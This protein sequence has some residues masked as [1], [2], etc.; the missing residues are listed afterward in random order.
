MALDVWDRRSAAGYIWKWSLISE[1]SMLSFHWCL[2][3]QRPSDNHLQT[4]G[5]VTSLSHLH[6]GRLGPAGVLPGS[7]TAFQP[8][9]S[10]GPRLVA[11]KWTHQETSAA[12]LSDCVDCCWEGFFKDREGGQSTTMAWRKERLDRLDGILAGGPAEEQKEQLSLTHRLHTNV[13]AGTQTKT[14]RH[15]PH[16]QPQ[17][18]A[19]HCC[20]RAHRD[21]RTKAVPQDGHRKQAEQKRSRIRLKLWTHFNKVV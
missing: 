3:L 16:A 17:N 18:K 4:L 5:P 6:N 14:R 12:E 21:W 19:V 2:C 9:F 7:R 15:R 20:R 8:R 11:R 1:D 13:H 10:G